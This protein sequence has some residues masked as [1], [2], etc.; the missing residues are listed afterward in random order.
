MAKNTIFQ[1]RAALI[2]IPILG[3]FLFTSNIGGAP[4]GYSGS[5]GDSGNYCSSCH[6]GGTYTNT[7]FITTDIPTSG[8]VLGQTY[9]VTVTPQSDAP[10]HGFE[11]TAENSSNVKVGGFATSANTQYAGAAN[12]AVTHTAPITSGVWTFNWT[13]PSSSQGAITFYAA[14][15]A[16]N[17]DGQAYVDGDSPITTS[18]SVNEATA[19]VTTAHSFFKLKNNPIKDNIQ[20]NF[21]CTINKGTAAIYNLNGKLIKTE[22]FSNANTLTIDS[23][24]LK[25][26][27]YIFEI[28]SGSLKQEM[29]II[30]L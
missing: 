22:T 6:Y 15:N 17:D 26:G 16:V 28:K 10:K 18:L 25:T 7:S 11:I 21:D 12:D 24:F 9:T 30:K 23:A 20:V 1:F 5:P 3:L 13:A 14:I 19:G 29:R 8:Y 27:I 4:Y 2:L